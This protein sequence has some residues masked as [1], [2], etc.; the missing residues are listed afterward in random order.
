[1]SSLPNGSSVNKVLFQGI[2]F[3]C[4]FTI[5]QKEGKVVYAMDGLFGYLRRS[6]PVLATDELY[7]DICSF[8]TRLMLTSLSF[9]VNT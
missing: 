6:Q 4:A 1:M 7:M 8:Q 2:F 3:A 5:F 9:R